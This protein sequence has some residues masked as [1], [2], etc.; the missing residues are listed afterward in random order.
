[1]KWDFKNLRHTFWAHT[2][3]ST[4]QQNFEIFLQEAKEKKKKLA[5]AI[6]KLKKYVYYIFTENICFTCN[7]MQV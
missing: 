2:N 1:M 6:F 5:K 3:G 7:P 4:M